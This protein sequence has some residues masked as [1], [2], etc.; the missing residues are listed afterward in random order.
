MK[1]IDG[2]NTILSDLERY[3]LIADYYKRYPERIEPNSDY[4]VNITDTLVDI[5]EQIPNEMKNQYWDLVVFFGKNS[6]YI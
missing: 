2:I 5:K 6:E 4:L 1:Q 3:N